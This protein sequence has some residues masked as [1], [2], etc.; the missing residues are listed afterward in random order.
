MGKNFLEPLTC[1]LKIPKVGNKDSDGVQVG[2]IFF[3][4]C[5]HLPFYSFVE[6]ART[7]NPGMM[8]TFFIFLFFYLQ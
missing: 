2:G 4:K 5:P 8:F 3:F 6:K 7:W 1:K